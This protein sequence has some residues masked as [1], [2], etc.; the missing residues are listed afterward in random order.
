M[1]FTYSNISTYNC[2]TGRIHVFKFLN[3]IRENLTK[4]E[5]TQHVKH[6]LQKNLSILA[7]F[8]IV[9]FSHNVDLIEH[10]IQMTKLY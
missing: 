7:W 10:K 5:I 8:K 3:A 1:R 9:Y 2:T 6:D 4:N